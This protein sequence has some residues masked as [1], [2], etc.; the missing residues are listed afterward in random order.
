MKV[1]LCELRDAIKSQIG[2]VQADI[3][4]KLNREDRTIS[5]R[6][7]R[8]TLVALMVE[9]FQFLMGLVIPLQS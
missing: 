4:L 5:F 3:H 2:V 9:T 8:M 1:P 6:I 7:H